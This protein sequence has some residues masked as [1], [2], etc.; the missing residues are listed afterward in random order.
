[1]SSRKNAV[2]E[3]S[4]VAERARKLATD[5]AAAAQQAAA[6][7]EEAASIMMANSRDGA[8]PASTRKGPKCLITGGCGF[9]GHHT[10][11]HFIKNTDYQII[12]LDK[13]SYASKGPSP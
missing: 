9:I 4:E 8:L 6:A 12:V 10:V 1:M 11:E 7:A 13:L 2:A 3:V 5:A